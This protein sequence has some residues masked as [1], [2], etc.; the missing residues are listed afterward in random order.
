MAIIIVEDVREHVE[1]PFDGLVH[2]EQRNESGLKKIKA[3]DYL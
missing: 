2:P 3:M 1:R